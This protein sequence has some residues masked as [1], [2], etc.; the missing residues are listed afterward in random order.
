MGNK[1]L[2]GL[3]LTLLI[4]KSGQALNIAYTVVDR[5]SKHMDSCLLAGQYPFLGKESFL[6][7]V[8]WDFLHQLPGKMIHP[9]SC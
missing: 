7:T 9:Q 1:V 2:F 5:Q 3:E 8:N 6:P 4:K